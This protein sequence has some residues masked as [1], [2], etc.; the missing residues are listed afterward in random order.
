MR[1]STCECSL[2]LRPQVGRVGGMGEGGN[3][4]KH[5]LFQNGMDRHV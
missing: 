5:R 2:T 4:Y 3:K 1:N